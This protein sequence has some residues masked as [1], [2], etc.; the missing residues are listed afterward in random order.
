MK[1]VTFDDGRVGRL[2]LEDETVI[3]LDVPSTREWF[4]R[5]GRGGRDRRAARA[6]RRTAARPDH[7]QEVLPHGRQLRRPPRGARGRRLVAPRAQGDRVL[8]ERRRDRRPRRRH[9]LSRGPDQGAR[10]RARAGDRDRPHRQVVRRRRGGGA[11]HRRLHRLQRHHRPRHPAPRDAVGGVQLLQGHRHVLPDRALDRDGR[12]DPRPA[13]PGDGAARQRRGA[14]A[15]QHQRHAD[16][17]P[18]PGRVPLAAGLLR[19]RPHHDRH[20][21]AASPRSSRTRST[22]TSSPAT[23]S[24]PRSRASALLRNTIVPWSAAHDTPPYAMDLY[25]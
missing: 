9:R 20:D 13:G 23:W 25:A 5:G 17:D 6:R 10:L 19:R 12:R 11:V 8:P 16:L 1:L 15:R 7:A 22:S 4:E 2:E 3:E 21:L 24:R 18:A 14:P